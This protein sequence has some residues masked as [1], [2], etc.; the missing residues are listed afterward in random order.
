MEKF[1]LNHVFT[2]VRAGISLPIN[3]MSSTYKIRN[4]ITLPLTFLYTQDSSEFF[5]KPKLEMVSSKRMYQLRDACFN[6]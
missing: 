4:T 6:P 2:E 5:L 1:S 3:N